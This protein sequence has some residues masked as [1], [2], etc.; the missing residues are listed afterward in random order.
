MTT[1]IYTTLGASRHKGGIVVRDNRAFDDHN[2]V[3]FFHDPASGL[4]AIIALHRA[5]QE[6]SV[7]GCRVRF[8]A[9]ED[10]AL[11]DVLLLSRSMTC[12]SVMAGLAYGGAEAVIIDTPGAESHQAR[13]KALG[14]IVHRYAGRFRVGVDLGLKPRD[15]RIMSMMTP[16]VLGKGSMAAADATALGVLST[17]R[18]AVRHRLS[19]PDLTNLRVAVQG[20]GNVGM[21]LLALLAEAGAQVTASDIDSAKIAVARRHHEVR[22][23]DPDRIHAAEV[24]VFCPCALGGVLNVMSIKD[25]R[26]ALVVGAAN[27]QLAVPGFGTFLRQKQV[28]Y[29]PD[30]LA[31]AGGLIAAAAELR[32]ESEGWIRDKIKG[33]VKTLKGLIAEADRRDTS[34]DAVSDRTAEKR[35]AAIDSAVHVAA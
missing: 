19:V 1:D 23:V 2:D 18:A 20:L 26:A 25:M 13:F 33:Q 17:M 4:R 34:L 22:I 32:N 10:E 28:L 30:Y 12:K 14:A 15:L 5:W 6:P 35:I 9:S 29:V 8:Y 27:N 11:A 24:D 16:F 31:N 21:R 3:S 7:G